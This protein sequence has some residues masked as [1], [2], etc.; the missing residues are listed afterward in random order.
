MS[1]RTE[2]FASRPSAASSRTTLLRESGLPSVSSAIAA[3]SSGDGRTGAVSSMNDV[4]SFS[5]K[6][7]EEDPARRKAGDIVQGCEGRVS[8]LELRLPVRRKHEHRRVCKLGGDELKQEERRRIGCV[9][10]V[11]NEEHRPV[12]RHGPQE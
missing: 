3:M 1:V 6:S 7:A 11:E 12:E 4:I 5:C 8:R 9:D 2:R 10:V